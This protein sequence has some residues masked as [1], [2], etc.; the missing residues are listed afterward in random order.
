MSTSQPGAPSP[1]CSRFPAGF[2]VP[3]KAPSLACMT[4][5]PGQYASPSASRI[6]PR[7][8]ARSCHR[9]SAKSRAMPRG[10]APDRADAPRRAV[11][12]ASPSSRCGRQMRRYNPRATGRAANSG[13]AEP[14]PLC[15]RPRRVRDNSAHPLAG[16]QVPHRPLYPAGGPGR[17]EGADCRASRARRHPHRMPAA[18]RLCQQRKMS[19]AFAFTL[20][21]PSAFAAIGIV[22]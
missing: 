16:R 14:R 11:A 5:L 20:S 7:A 12:A 1:K 8:S 22:P 21:N 15:G 9:N 18:R 3:A 2:A 10:A 4:F 19:T 6:S 17:R 13:L